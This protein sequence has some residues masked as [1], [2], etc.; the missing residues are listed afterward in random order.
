MSLA[1]IQ[2]SELEKLGK[3]FGGQLEKKNLKRLVVVVQKNKRL[4]ETY[5][6]DIS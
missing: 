6:E 4:R 2:L 5:V 1:E 3:F